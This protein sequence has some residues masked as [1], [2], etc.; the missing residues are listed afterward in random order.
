MDAEELWADDTAVAA[1]GVA[2]D[3]F[4]NGGEG[5]VDVGGR[6]GFGRAEIVGE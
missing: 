5:G 2:A 1:L 3:G 6:G 4:L